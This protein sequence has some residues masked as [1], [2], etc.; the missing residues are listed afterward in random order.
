MVIYGFA[1]NNNLHLPQLVCR[2][3]TAQAVA[4]PGSDGGA[5]LSSLVIYLR[6]IARAYP[7]T[8][9][10]N[11]SFNQTAPELDPDVISYL[12][13]EIRGIAREY[14]ILPVISVGNKG[15]KNP[16]GKLC[17]P[18]DCEAAITVGGRKFDAKGKPAG[19]CDVSLTGPGPDGMFK[20]DLSWFSKLRMIGGSSHRGSSYSTPLVASLAA[21]TFAKLKDPSPDLVKALLINRAEREAHC[22]SHGWGT[23]Y[24]GQVPWQCDP[25]TVTMVW[26]AQ[27][28]P[29][30]A[31]YWRDIPIPPEMIKDGKL[32]GTANLTAILDPL[33]SETGGPNY[34]STRLQVALQYTKAAGVVGN[35]LG[36]MKEDIEAELTARADLAK[37]CPVRSHRRDFTKRGGLTFSGAAFQLH[38]RVFARDLFQYDLSAQG[39]LGPQ[40]VAFVL[41][42]AGGEPDSG[43]YNSTAVRLGNFVDSAVIDQ[44]IQITAET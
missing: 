6:E 37:W 21:H 18:A 42:L 11:L 34:F 24:D 7:E 1:W 10:W 41:T 5:D 39:E 20:P 30:Y 38:A 33:V 17:G 26:R 23:P 22:S 16:D 4:K 44:S 31:Y 36:S 43:I 15:P 35:L 12:G 19:L 28:L 29:G 14:D 3:G 13:H 40:E 8:K 32:F 27:L 2:V 25:G 9:V